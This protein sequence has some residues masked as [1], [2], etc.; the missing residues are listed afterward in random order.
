M[1]IRAGI[2][3][4]QDNKVALIERHRAGLDYF[5]FPGGGVD[6]GESP[7]QAAVREAMEELGIEVAIKRKVAEVQLG[8]KSHQVYF[9][10]EQVGGEFGTGTGEEFVGSDPDNPQKGIYIPIWMSIDELPQHTNVYPADVSRLVVRSLKDGW[11][12]DS[13]LS[14]EEP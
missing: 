1:R 6:E 2:V 4:I 9:L 5:V 12:Q 11:S 14:F 3:L 8:P 7:E 13:I 10:V